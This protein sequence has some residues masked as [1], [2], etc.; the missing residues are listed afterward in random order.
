[1]FVQA[2]NPNVLHSNLFTEDGTSSL[3]ELQGP[4]DGLAWARSQIE[5]GRLGEAAQAL[6][7]ILQERNLTPA[8]R[9]RAQNQLQSLQ[10]ES[11]FTT[12]R[13]EFLMQHVIPQVLDPVGLGSMLGA[14]L[15]FKLS[16][17]A[18]L[19]GASRLGLQGRWLRPAASLGAFGLE[20]SSFPMWANLGQLALGHRVDWEHFDHQVAS[21]FLVLGGLKG[22]GRAGQGLQRF[23][24]GSS[25]APWRRALNQI[26][27]YGG[28]VSGHGAE[29]YLG[30]APR[31]GMGQLLGESAVIWL[32][33]NAA[34]RILPHLTGG[35]LRHFE[36][37]LENIWRHHGV[38]SRVATRNSPASGARVSG[39]VPLLGL[40]VAQLF[41]PAMLR[42]Q[43][44]A[45]E[46]L[47]QNSGDPT[48]PWLLGIATLGLLS[49]M[50]VRR[51]MQYRYRRMA[52]EAREDPK[53]LQKLARSLGH[54]PDTLQILTELGRQNPD[55]IRAMDEAARRAILE[56]PQDP[57]TERLYHRLRYFD[58]SELQELASGHPRVIEALRILASEPYHNDAAFRAI[59]Q[60]PIPKL[61]AMVPQAQADVAVA[62]TFWR[63]C[64]QLSLP[65]AWGVMLSLDWP[66]FLSRNIQDW[67]AVQ[68]SMAQ[69]YHERGITFA[70]LQDLPVIKMWDRTPPS[71]RA[72]ALTRAVEPLASYGNLQATELIRSLNP[73]S[74]AREIP[75]DP[76][77]FHALGVLGEYGVPRSADALARFAEKDAVALAHLV[78]LAHYGDKIALNLMHSLSLREYE[79]VARHDYNALS[80]LAVLNRQGHRGAQ[81][82]LER[83][84]GQNP[85]LEAERERKRSSE[86]P[87][88]RVES[89]KFHLHQVCEFYLD[90]FSSLKETEKI[91]IVNH[92][93]ND[94]QALSPQEKVAYFDRD[95]RGAFSSKIPIS[96]IEETF[97]ARLEG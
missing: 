17:W 97:L 21:S 73:K 91:H 63:I 12:D 62:Y 85:F 79:G 13:L 78:R 69:V 35:S 84:F 68:M 20:A 7:H 96:F 57:H 18:L 31:Q 58:V 23:L 59:Q 55:A 80:A 46:S 95:R 40:G 64:E 42:A 14:G 39:W 92:I 29:Q 74:L 81:R 61:E 28:V 50:A 24:P 87:D 10:G 15:T 6:S 11:G 47:P 43:E 3:Q 25:R 88:T 94:W 76:G 90:R 34:A 48:L 71:E 19:G 51:Y 52:R 75:A 60:I 4:A 86:S 70:D 36:Q 66:E 1:M 8:L 77:L 49:T 45:G 16:R 72:Q 22:F 30:L 41:E 89:P 33:F 83:L 38:L 9:T 37:E 2:G 67:R 26:A 56:A 5:S 93:W 32:H 53:M 44:R 54:R 82:A 65:N 27:M